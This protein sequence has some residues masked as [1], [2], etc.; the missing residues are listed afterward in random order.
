MRIE[1]V[2]KRGNSCGQPK[3]ALGVQ[4]SNQGY[5][6]VRV[7]QKLYFQIYYQNMNN[8]IIINS[9]LS[10]VDRLSRC[11]W[12]QRTTTRLLLFAKNMS[13]SRSSSAV[14][15]NLF[16]YKKQSIVF[17]TPCTPHFR[18]SRTRQH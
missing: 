4:G 8:V 6:N 17:G 2:I 12:E 3:S 10:V 13:S 9:S 15:R 14:L 7:Q 1:E 18:I 16:N 11:C 5:T